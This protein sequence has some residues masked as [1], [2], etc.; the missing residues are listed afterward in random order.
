M[1]ETR[2][3]LNADEVECPNCG[4]NVD[5]L[6]DLELH[7]DQAE[8]E[9]DCPRCEVT[10]KIRVVLSKAYIATWEP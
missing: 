4:A 8:G 3:I 10:I 5:S 2:S 1:S 9:A 7:A 6:D